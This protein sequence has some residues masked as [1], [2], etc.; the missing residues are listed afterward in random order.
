MHHLSTH[1]QEIARAAGHGEQLSNLLEEA[2]QRAVPADR[3]HLER[4]LARARRL[5]AER[6]LK[7]PLDRHVRTVVLLLIHARVLS[8][9][10]P[11]HMPGTINLDE[12]ARADHDAHIWLTQP[13]MPNCF[14]DGGNV[15]NCGAAW[16]CHHDFL[17]V[18]LLEGLLHADE[19]V[20]LD[21]PAALD[22]ARGW[23]H[24]KTSYLPPLFEAEPAHYRQGWEA[25]ARAVD[26]Q[27]QGEAA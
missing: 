17:L 8:E 1:A 9:C 11:S 12:F 4:D 19:V 3:A 22:F 6:R 13:G 15:H 2:L 5:E 16:L 27:Q 25:A 7:V 20:Q 10:S 26:G 24:G 14:P 21:G 18:S 23:Y